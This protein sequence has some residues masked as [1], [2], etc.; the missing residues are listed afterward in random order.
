MNKLLEVISV[1]KEY[2]GLGGAV[3]ALKG[4][5]LVIEAG[6]FFSIVGPS[7]AGKSTLLHILGGLESPT[8]G[9][10][11][12]K[13]KDIYKLRDK[14]LS[15]WRSKNIGFVFQFYHLIEELNVIEN[16]TLPLRLS[17]KKYSLKQGQEL[18]KY[19]GIED[20]Q[21]AFPSQL[22]GGQKQKAAF[23]RA[24]INSPEVI[25]CDEP[26]GNLDKNS[27]E[28]II[29]LLDRLNREK[30]K[31]V[32]LVTHNLELAKRA[33]RIVFIEDGQLKF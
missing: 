29:D 25:L 15:L 4:V 16:I 6:D 9:K 5:S 28:K 14:E 12:F 18:L 30:N 32:V 3:C 2:L 8:N 17:A 1:E 22:S 23:A 13:G 20:K 11:V 24:L 27:Q 31:T 21:Y 7:G 19:L 33:K 10:V 26:T